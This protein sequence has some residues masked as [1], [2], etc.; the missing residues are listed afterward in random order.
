MYKVTFSYKGY[1]AGVYFNSAN[2]KKQAKELA[3]MQCSNKYDSVRVE[4]T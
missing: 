2:N 4:E 3:V 1:V